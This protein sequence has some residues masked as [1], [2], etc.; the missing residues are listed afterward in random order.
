MCALSLSERECEWEMKMN[1][2]E[3]K[4]EKINELLSKCDDLSLISLI[5]KILVKSVPG[6]QQ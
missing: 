2:K 3:I 1:I 5:E 6:E 4:I